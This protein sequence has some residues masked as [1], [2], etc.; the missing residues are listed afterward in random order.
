MLFSFVYL[1]SVFWF[2]YNDIINLIHEPKALDF[3]LIEIKEDDQIFTP[4]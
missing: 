1:N 4:Y 2:F 3:I